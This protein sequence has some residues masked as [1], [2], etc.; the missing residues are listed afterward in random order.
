[1]M[2]YYKKHLSCKYLTA[3]P[4]C[5]D[6][7]VSLSIL[8]YV[9]WLL[10]YH[11]SS[12]PLVLCGDRKLFL[13]FLI[14]GILSC[15]YYTTVTP[16]ASRQ[17]EGRNK[18]DFQVYVLK[19]LDP[20]IWDALHDRK[21]LVGVWMCGKNIPTQLVRVRQW[22]ICLYLTLSASPHGRW[23]YWPRASQAEG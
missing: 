12:N 7:Y 3:V 16:A 18:S 17:S 13:C 23:L 9:S 6:Y 15:W 21:D 2:L 8:H 14:Y 5:P 1:M 4:C 11:W 22:L 19:T 10:T 20:L